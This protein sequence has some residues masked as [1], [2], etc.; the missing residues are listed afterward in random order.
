M[1]KALPKVFLLLIN[2]SVFFTQVDAQVSISSTNG[3][4]VN[5]TVRPEAIVPSSSSCTW[6]Y[7]YN[8]TVRY[9][10]SF[11]GSNIPGSMYT[12]QGVLGCG[13]N[14]HFF[15]VPNNGG[16]GVVTSQSNVWNPNSDCNTATVSSLN[17][18]MV[19]LEIEGPGISHR[20]V[21]FAVST[22]ALPVKL[23]DFSAGRKNKTVEL[24]WATASES[25]NSEFIIERSKDGMNWDSIGSQRG[26][27]NSN[28]R[29]DYQFFDNN[30]PV[31]VSYYR[32]VQMDISGSSS[33][34]AIRKVDAADNSLG[35]GLYPVPNT[36]NTIH[37]TGL[38]HPLQT[39]IELITP[40]G[41]LIYQTRL[42]GN[43]QELPVLKPGL[44]LIRITD[45]NTNQVST[46]KYIRQ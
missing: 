8:V 27:G 17:C 22:T 15:N 13:S 2:C 35:I 23:I 46:I 36:G 40:A 18:N 3:Y 37:F 10:I 31:T 19:T 20:F 25:N 42:T 9:N 11:T 4:N 1:K 5:V 6:G 29:A 45:L 14:S 26:R 16:A 7:N 41:G 38:A 24:N 28:E 21:S 34:S 12:L 30:P 33:Y 44:Y 32:L 43:S 39:Q